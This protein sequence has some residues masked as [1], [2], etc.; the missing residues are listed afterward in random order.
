[1]KTFTIIIPVFN[2]EACIGKLVEALDDFLVAS[3]LATNVLFVDDGSTDSSLDLIKKYCAA[4]KDFMYLSLQKNSGLSTALKAGIDYATA[5]IVG[6]MD[7]DLQTTPADFLKLLT[8]LPDYDLVMGYREKR[9]DSLIK[10]L[11]SRIANTVRKMLLHDNIIDTGCPLKVLK[12][13][14]ARRLPFFK[15]IHRFFP[16]AVIML[17]GRVKQVPVQHFQRYG[18]KPKYNLFNRLVGPF[19]DALVFRWMQRNYIRYEIKEASV[20]SING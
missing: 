17:G 15:G 13:T 4:R 2:E 18:G 8:Y 9:K 11:S 3:P 20:D 14:Y 1:M 7:A 6:Y 19:V 16:N 5:D 12:T 10:K